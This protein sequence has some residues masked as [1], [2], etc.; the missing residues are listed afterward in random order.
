MVFSSWASPALSSSSHAPH[1]NP[2]ALAFSDMKSFCWLY[3]A[4]TTMET[5]FLLSPSTGLSLLVPTLHSS[6]H[7]SLLP[8]HLMYV[9]AELIM[10][11]LSSHTVENKLII[12]HQ[13]IYIN[14]SSLQCMLCPVLSSARGH[15]SHSC[16]QWGLSQLYL[17]TYNSSVGMA[18]RRRDTRLWLPRAWTCQPKSSG[19]LK[20]LFMVRIGLPVQI[21][22]QYCIIS[23]PACLW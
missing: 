15:L 2:G 19:L 6:T 22:N 20:T 14:I 18:G 10:S 9:L 21:R 16:D 1:T 7:S 12:C 4:V 13:C 5:L 17:L 11:W 23:Q 8:W 3:Y